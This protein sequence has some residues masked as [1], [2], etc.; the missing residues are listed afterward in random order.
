GQVLDLPDLFGGQRLVVAEVEPQPV[1]RDQRALLLDVLAQH[2]AQGPVE[3]VGAGVVAP[4][5][6]APLA[7]DAG[8]G[9]LADLDRALPHPHD[10]LVQA[11]QRVDGVDHLGH[12]GGRDDDAGVAHLAA[13][14]GVEGRAVEVDAVADD[15]DDGGLRLV[16]LA[17]GE[18]GRA[19][20][21]QQ[22]LLAGHLVAGGHAARLAVGPGPPALLL[23]GRL[24][25]AHA[26]P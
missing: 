21:G 12:A 9:L 3:D 18:L 26:A 19:V 16:L 23:H 24:A 17:A 22:L 1:G 4:D 25:A 11:G 13:G 10:V 2:L 6:V 7:V 8:V 20:L 5:G 15:A 14:L